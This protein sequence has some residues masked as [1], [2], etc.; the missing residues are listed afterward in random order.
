MIYQITCIMSA[1]KIVDAIKNDSTSELSP[2][3]SDEAFVVTFLLFF[4]SSFSWCAF[5]YAASF[6]FKSDVASF[7]TVLIVSSVA[8]FLDMIC[9]FVYLFVKLDN[10]VTF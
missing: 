5:A 4:I 9:A 3:V 7:I 6:M 1:I 2:I 8:G 10:Q